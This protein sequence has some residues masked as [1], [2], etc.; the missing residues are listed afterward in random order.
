MTTL[1]LTETQLHILDQE[2]CSALAETLI[3]R[4]DADDPG[5]YR[6]YSERRRELVD[7]RHLI[8]GSLL[9][10]E[11]PEGQQ[12]LDAQLQAELDHRDPVERYG[13][14]EHEAW[15]VELEMVDA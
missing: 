11:K 3:A 15:L 7:L 1:E 13:T 6:A 2:L 4:D 9:E 10:Y 5:M 12:R 8:A 14:A